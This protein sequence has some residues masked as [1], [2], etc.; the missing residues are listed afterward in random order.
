MIVYIVSIVA[1]LA[2]LLF[3]VA[4]FANALREGDKASR[5]GDKS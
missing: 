3:P 1:C 4:T 5:R 2:A